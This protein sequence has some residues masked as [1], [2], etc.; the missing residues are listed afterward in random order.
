M[1][2]PWPQMVSGIMVRHGGFYDT[3][4]YSDT[5]L[6]SYF[7]QSRCYSVSLQC[8]RIIVKLQISAVMAL[9][10]RVNV[11]GVSP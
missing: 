6:D 3:P 8:V 9:G 10:H 7:C 5:M 2:N 4:L 1:I 11:R